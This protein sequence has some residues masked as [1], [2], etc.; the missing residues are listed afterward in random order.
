M[1]DFTKFRSPPNR[2]MRRATGMFRPRGEA[3]EQ[4]Q[5]QQTVRSTFYKR[6][7]LS[8][9]G[10]LAGRFAQTARNTVNQLTKR[11]ARK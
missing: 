11:G 2:T 1:T 9:A 8:R 6:R 10:G 7:A 4:T 5:K 3:D